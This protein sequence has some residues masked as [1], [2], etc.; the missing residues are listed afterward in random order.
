VARI[1]GDHRSNIGVGAD[2]NKGDDN[3]EGALGREL[4][5]RPEGTKIKGRFVP[6]GSNSGIQ[7]AAE[8]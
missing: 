2:E 5:V 6:A 7:I 8:A 4:I 3:V 1:S